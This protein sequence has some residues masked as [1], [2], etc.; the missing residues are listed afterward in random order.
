[1]E[2]TLEQAREMA[3]LTDRIAANLRFIQQDETDLDTV[4]NQ[5]NEIVSNLDA[6]AIERRIAGLEDDRDALSSNTQQLRE[7]LQL[8]EQEVAKAQ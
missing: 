6:I 5:T 4:F 3:E 8:L 7:W 1:M 2:M